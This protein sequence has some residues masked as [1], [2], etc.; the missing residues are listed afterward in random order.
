[1]VKELWTLDGYATE[2]GESPIRTFLSGL[3]ASDRVEAVA[4][5]QLARNQGTPYVFRTQKLWGMDCTSYEENRCESFMFSNLV[6]GSS[7]STA[8]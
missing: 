3:E 2:Q 8:C 7:L 5:I 6:D 4:L 1:M